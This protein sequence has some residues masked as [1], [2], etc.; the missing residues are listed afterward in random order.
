MPINFS[1]PHGACDCHIH[2]I[3]DAELFP[4][5]PQRGYTPP[6]AS[7][8]QLLAMHKQVGIE[9]F[10]IVS[11]SVYGTDNRV[12]L[13]ILRRLPRHVRGVAVIDEKT[14]ESEL[15]DMHRLGVRGVRINMEVNREADPAP[16][17][18]KLEE[19][20]RR[21][22]RLGWHIQAN[23]R[24]S[25]IEAAQD[26]LAALPVMLVVDHFGHLRANLGLQQPGMQAL[27]EL[28]RAGR[29][30][31]KLSAVYQASSEADYSDMLPY[32]RACIEANLQRVLW[33]SNWPHPDLRTI[34]ERPAETVTPY[35]V[36]DNEAVFRLLPAWTAGDPAVLQ[37]LLVD[38]PA[39]LYDFE[40]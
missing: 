32:A 21:I 33:G 14:S 26:R 9:R 31:V 1:V 34:K 17:L 18:E 19:T 10:V 38:N 8:K 27:L 16:F 15:D 35:R 6:G 39:R 30:Y 23:I 2:I 25:V 5:S 3:P 29:S 20:A 40:S 22:E 24:L 28:L 7:L 11:P 4:F 37:A 36:V 12:T 13:D